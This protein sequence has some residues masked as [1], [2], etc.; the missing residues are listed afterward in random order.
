MI[1]TKTGDDGT[2]GLIGGTRVSKSDIRLE[3]YGTADEL[4]SFIGL[5][6]AQAVST[7]IDNILHIIQN[8]LFILGAYLATDISVATIGENSRITANM[9][10]NLEKYIDTYTAELPA[11]RNFILPGGNQAV[12]ICHI[13][14]TITRRLERQM[15]RLNTDNQL[16][17]N[18]LKYTNRLSDFFFILSRKIASDM[19]CEIFLWEK[20]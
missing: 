8:Q 14:R 16:D 19:K 5:L 4:N 1:Y 11:M 2:S 18:A 15:V 6:R 7:S 10:E 3:A 13:C 12:S 17:T 9:T 20:M